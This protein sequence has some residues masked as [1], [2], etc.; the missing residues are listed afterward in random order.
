MGEGRGVVG[1]FR[2]RILG[3]R[4]T[5]RGLVSFPGHVGWE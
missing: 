1:A 5:L 2:S 4:L 3:M